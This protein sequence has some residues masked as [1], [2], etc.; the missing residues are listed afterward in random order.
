MFGNKSQPSRIYRYGAKA[1]TGGLEAVR[2][3]MRAAHRYRNALIEQ[4][5]TRRAA[6]EAALVAM[7]PDLAATEQKLVAAEAAVE[8]AVT[9]LKAAQGA[10]R[11]RIRPPALT[12]AVKEAKAARKALFAQRKAQRKALFASD[13]WKRRQE[14]IDAGDLAARKKLRADCGVYWGTYLFIEQSL[15]GARRG[16]PP[17]FRRWQGDGTCAVQLQGG[18]SWDELA[19]GTDMRLRLTRDP[20]CQRT[21]RRAGTR[22]IA[23]VRVGTDPD[24]R[25]PVWA[26]VPVVLHR[27]V[28]A[29]ARVKWAYLKV[30]RVGVAEDWSLALV[31]SRDSWARDDVATTGALGLDVGWRLTPRGLRVAV[32][33]DDQGE[34]LEIMLRDDKLAKWGKADAIESER[35]TRFNV[36]RADLGSWLRR[37]DVTVPEWPEWLVEATSTLAQWRSQA[38]LDV[39]VRRWRDARVP[40]DETIYP[41]LVQWRER[42]RHLCNYAAG[43]RRDF[44]R[45]RADVYRNAA[46]AIARRYGTVVIERLDLR[47]FHVLPDA[48]QEAGPE[49]PRAYVRHAAL[50][51]LVQSLKEAVRTVALVDPAG[52]TIDCAGCGEPAD[53]DRMRLL[54]PCGTCGHMEDQDV[55]AARNIL[56]RW[57]EG[58]GGEG[59]SGNRS[60]PQGGGDAEDAAAGSG[61]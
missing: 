29:D 9:A 34:R 15:T 36:A 58:S 38:R 26:T 52:T 33:V 19:S 28:P 49:A 50:H 43:L 30:R 25:G 18:A 10:A 6:V 1:P 17:K 16:A 31:C 14:Q 55:R 22:W 40:G 4:E 27:P 7:A 5:R 21:G 60:Q 57:R 2:D 42:D 8:G 37:K 12:G 39:L 53:F 45:Y 54:A 59:G 32:G 24:T 61:G 41:A 44:A 3:Q 11:K 51:V 48:E 23:S 20:N 46:R 35:D 47:D 56:S 13:A